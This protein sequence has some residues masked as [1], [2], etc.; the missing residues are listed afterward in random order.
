MAPNKTS[1]PNF[2]SEYENKNWH[3]ATDRGD[4]LIMRLNGVTEVS[5][6]PTC[7]VVRQHKMPLSNC[8]YVRKMLSGTNY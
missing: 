3:A 1:K 6:D 2:P 4:N 7:P 5:F 8:D